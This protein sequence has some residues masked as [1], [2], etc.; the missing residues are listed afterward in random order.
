MQLELNSVSVNGREWNYRTISQYT[1]AGLTDNTGNI[2]WAWNMHPNRSGL[3]GFD[4]L[5]AGWN[6]GIGF[7][8]GTTSANITI[9]NGYAVVIGQN[10][11]DPIRLVRYTNGLDANANITNIIAS[12]SNLCRN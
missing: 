12:G 11:T 9:G 6:Y 4:S 7:V 5:T 1:T 2:T 8:L 10:L 3:S